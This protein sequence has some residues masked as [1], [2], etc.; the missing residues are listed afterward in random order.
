VLATAR[1]DA[2]G[3]LTRKIVSFRRIGSGYRRSDETH[4]LTLLPARDLSK[5]L[6]A[7]GFSVRAGGGLFEARRR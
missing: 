4:R 6:R 1:E 2:R 3:R 7:A 5:R